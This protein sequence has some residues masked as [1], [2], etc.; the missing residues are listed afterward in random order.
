[1]L[2]SDFAGC[3][4]QHSGNGPEAV[5]ARGTTDSSGGGGAVVSRPCGPTLQATAA[6]VVWFLILWNGQRQMRGLRH[7][8]EPTVDAQV[9]PFDSQEATSNKSSRNI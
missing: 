8:R 4:R 2:P 6:K 5:A 9:H 7:V 3:C 1:M